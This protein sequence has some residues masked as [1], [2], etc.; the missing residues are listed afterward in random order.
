MSNKLKKEG[1]K[2]I[3]G[4]KLYSVGTGRINPHKSSS[5]RAGRYIRHLNGYLTAAHSTSASVWFFGSI[6]AAVAA[7]KAMETVG[8]KCQEKIGLFEGAA[9]NEIT[10]VR[11]VT[12]MELACVDI[13]E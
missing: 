9:N 11:E 2:P 8:I 3:P 12:D 5:I 1:W 13:P 4:Q 10:Y 6:K 7:K